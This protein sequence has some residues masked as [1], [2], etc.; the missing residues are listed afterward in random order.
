MAIS[1][2]LGM[3]GSTSWDDVTGLRPENYRERLLYE[4]PNG[5]FPITS[6]IA[7]QGGKELTDDYS[8]HWFE[9][10]L[11]T[12]SGASTAGEIYCDAN[13]TNAYGDGM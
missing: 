11:P 6:I 4:Y 2:Q 3:R 13:F 9:E 7:T 5:D 1:A 12:F 10:E 8:F